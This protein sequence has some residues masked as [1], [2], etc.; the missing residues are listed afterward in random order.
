MAIT[1]SPSVARNAR[2][3]MTVKV[4]PNA[5]TETAIAEKPRSAPV[6]QRTT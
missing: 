2:I 3:S 6:I 1:M 5:R 4:A